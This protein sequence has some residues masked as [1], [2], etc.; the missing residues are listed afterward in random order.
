MHIDIKKSLNL[1]NYYLSQ[2]GQRRNFVICGGA[3]LVL[4]GV[5][6]RGTV[7]VDIVGPEMDQVLKDA[8]DSV[9]HDLGF[10][11]DWLNDD[12][13]KIFAKD[14]PKNWEA[15]AFEIYLESHLVIKSL[16]KLDFAL[17]KFLAECD[18]QKDLQDLVD[19]NLSESEIDK[20]V[21]H[22]LSRDPGSNNWPQVVA[23]VQAKLR[24]KLRYE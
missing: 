7:D 5:E 17:L 12:V 15:R 22:A 2:K 16:S 13:R 8:A 6:G 10:D 20:V 14:L 24:R 9:A 11:S 1:L 3:A 4:Q 18:R 19:L 23:E 21:K